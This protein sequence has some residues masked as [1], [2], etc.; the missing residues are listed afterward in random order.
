[1]AEA[2]SLP[3][4]SLAGLDSRP[5]HVGLISDEVTIGKSILILS[6]SS[7]SIILRMF[8]AYILYI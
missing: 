3:S 2:G 5:A 4:T 1:M 6:F 7:V 8:R